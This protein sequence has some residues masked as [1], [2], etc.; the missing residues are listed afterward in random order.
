LLKFVLLKSHKRP[1]IYPRDFRH[2]DKLPSNIISKLLD[3]ICSGLLASVEGIVFELESR[4]DDHGSADIITVEIFA[5][6]LQWFS[7][8]AERHTPK[9]GEDMTAAVI[10]TKVSALFI[11]ISCQYSHRAIA[12]ARNSRSHRRRKLPSPK[13]G[14][15]LKP[16]RPLLPSSVVFCVICP[17]TASTLPR[18]NETHSSSKVLSPALDF[19]LDS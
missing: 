5:F 6:L 1:V 13:D 16:S 2:F 18:P 3:S 17:R 8:A 9:D 11:L 4:K 14:P 19:G 15:G 7:A 10:K 12:R